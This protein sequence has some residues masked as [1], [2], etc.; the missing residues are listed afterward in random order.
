MFKNCEMIIQNTLLLTDKN[1]QLQMT[2]KRQTKKRSF[3]RSYVVRENVLIEKKDL[4]QTQLTAEVN[5]MIVVKAKKSS[6]T[7]ASS[8]CSY[9]DSSTYTARTCIDH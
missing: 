4:H 9:C 8:R 5:L 1:K 7:R 3:R 2:N 6:K